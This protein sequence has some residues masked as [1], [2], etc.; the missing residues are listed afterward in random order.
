MEPTIET[1]PLFAAVLLTAATGAALWLFHRQVAREKLGEDNRVARALG[2][3]RKAV[4]KLSK[5]EGSRT[6]RGRDCSSPCC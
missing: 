5:S 3:A 2:S 6:G 1:W 4:G